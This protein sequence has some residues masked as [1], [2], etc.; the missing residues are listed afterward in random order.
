MFLHIKW[1]IWTWNGWPTLL[2]ANINIDNNLLSALHSA[3]CLSLSFSFVFLFFSFLEKI[4][5][6]SCLVCFNGSYGPGLSSYGLIFFIITWYLW[7]LQCTNNMFLTTSFVINFVFGE[8]VGIVCQLDSVGVTSHLRILTGVLVHDAL[9]TCFVATHFE[10][11]TQF[12]FF[13]QSALNLG[14][15]FWVLTIMSECMIILLPSYH[16][17][18]RVVEMTKLAGTHLIK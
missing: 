5:R 12:E 3:L 8:I 15:A 14:R 10:K 1:T 4:R 6:G 18:A 13:F 17:T 2:I 7:N 11:I 9:K 16:P